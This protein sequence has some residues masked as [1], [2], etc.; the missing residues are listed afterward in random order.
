MMVCGQLIL[1][2]VLLLIGGWARA[3]EVAAPRSVEAIAVSTTE[4]RLYWLP[5]EGA[6]GYRVKRD[7]QE[8]ATLPATAQEFPDTGLPPDSTHRYEITAL[9]GERESPARAY[10][11]RTFAPFPAGRTGKRGQLPEATYDVVI[12]QASSGGVAAAYEAARRGLR[13]ALIEP[14]TRLDGM[15]A[16]GLSATDIRRPEHTSG[17]F[18]RFQ[19]RVRTLYAAEGVKTNGLQYEPRIAH[20]A[21]KS[22]LYEVPDLTIFRRARLARVFTRDV[23]DETA[24]TTSP[25]APPYDP[26]THLPGNAFT[27]FPPMRRRVE[28]VEV[29]ELGVDG[30]PTGRRALFRAAMFIDATDCGDLAAWAGAPFRIGRE[31]RT[32]SEPHAGVIYYD[33]AADKLLPGSNGQG[34]RRLMSYAYLLTVKD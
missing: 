26:I 15:P 4:I 3:Q 6:T 17:F 25:F 23:P 13:T 30:R 2:V 29:E 8:V 10:T 33:R 21:L 27:S 18:V 22:L 14:T 19:D 16:N 9:Q 28:A 34:D 7:G 1:A 11:E 31:P 24:A 5:A 20:Q 12:V 32:P